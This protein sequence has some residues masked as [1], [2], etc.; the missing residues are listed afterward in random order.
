MEPVSWVGTAVYATDLALR[1]V[2]ALRVIMRRLHVGVSLAWL[3]IILIFPFFGAV[4]YLLLG[5]Y[6]LG[7][8]RGRR[9]LIYRQGQELARLRADGAVSPE[10]LGV[11]GLALARLAESVLGSV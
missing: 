9:A 6:R 3:A 8:E 4:L 10:A 1:T 11:E 7:P 2:F 5:E